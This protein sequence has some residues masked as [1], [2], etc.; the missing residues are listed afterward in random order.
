MRLLWDRARSN[1]ALTR[2][3]LAVAGAAGMQ[4]LAAQLAAASQSADGRPRDY[5]RFPLPRLEPQGGFRVDP[6][7]LYGI[8]L[9]ESRFNGNAVSPAGA[10]GLMQIM[11]ATARFIGGEAAGARLHDPAT[12][13][14]LAQRY[15]H[16]LARLEV[17]EGNLIRLL[18]AYNAGPGNLA[19]WLPVHGHRDDPFLFTEAI[20]IDET[21]LYVQKVLANSWIYASR[22]GLSTPSLDQLAAGSFPRFAQGPELLAL[23]KDRP[24]TL[25]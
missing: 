25:H 18:A 21:R 8:A 23:L 1:P 3:M 4:G 9:Q 7:L 19:K 13:L 11:P 17:V 16:H 6:A 10:R 20:P 5:A 15:V 12:S 2:S 14:E 22:L 24:R